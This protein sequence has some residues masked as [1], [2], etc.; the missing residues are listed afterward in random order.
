MM[1][2][3]VSTAA[4]SNGWRG[5]RRL[6]LVAVSAVAAQLMG[7]ATNPLQNAQ[8]WNIEQ[9]SNALTPMV[10]F[11]RADGAILANIPRSTCAAVAS[12]A[13]KI[14]GVAGYR[15]EQIHI[16]DPDAPNAFATQDKDRRPVILVTL[17]MLKALGSDE[18]A[19]AG[20][21]GH[22]IAHHVRNHG[23]G[24]KE[25]QVGAQATGQVLG[26]VIAQ[27]IPGVG[28]IIAGNAASFAAAN[29]MYG[30]YTRPQERE[31][32]EL[33][34]RWMVASGYDPRGMERLFNALAKSSGAL[35]GFVSTH[36]G[37]ED[38]AKMVRDF[39]ASNAG[40]PASIPSST[41]GE[42]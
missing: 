7:C 5:L 10:R 39:I 13:S 22:E 25:A 20:L 29:S 28:G 23:A 38:R 8:I 26:S 9:C 37:A 2:A 41:P 42:Q 1:P 30:A 18:A 16:A 34:L 11:N 24:R 27:L 31:A 17:G 15:A 33:G 21:L 36:P 3:Q 6:T 35:P 12:A 32:D 40:A 19:W 4:V 14:E